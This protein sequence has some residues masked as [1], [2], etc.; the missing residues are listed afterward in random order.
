MD[1]HAVLDHRYDDLRQDQDGTPIPSSTF[2]AAR[3][4]ANCLLITGERVGVLSRRQQVGGRRT[5]LA[6]ISKSQQRVVLHQV[7]AARQLF[8]P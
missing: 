8:S 2:D 5:P 3:A 1:L 6:S 7:A 4:P